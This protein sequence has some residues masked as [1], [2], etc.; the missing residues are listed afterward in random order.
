VSTAFDKAAAEFGAIT[1]EAE[2]ER[3]LARFKLTAMESAPDEAFEPP[4]RTLGQYLEDPIEVPPVLVEPYIV[5]R[6]GITCTIG[7]AGKGK[8]VMNINR[9][10]RWAAGLPMFDTWTDPDKL[11]YLR[12]ANY[13]PL[14]ILVIENEGAGGLFHRQLGIML[15]AEGRFTDEQKALVK[16]NILIWGD[17]GYAGLKLDDPARLQQ[18][19][20][21]CDKYKPDIVFIEPF[22]GLWQGEENS[23]TDMAIVADAL[24]DVAS[25]FQCG[26][27]L[28]HHERKSGTGDDGEKMS[29]GRGSTV[30]EG[31]V[32]VMENFEAV[33]GGEF[34]ELLWSKSRHGGTPNPV[35]MEWDAESWWYN[36]VPEDSILEAIIMALRM[37][38]DEPMS[39]HDL[40]EATEESK[41]RLRK[42]ANEAAKTGRLKKM[43][44]VSDGRGSTGA[45]YRLPTSEHDATGGLAI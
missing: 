2:R 29:A 21:G 26:I 40:H 19:K 31:V 35:R 5:V 10:F 8:T 4:I 13:E 39:V 43:P 17:G 27:M 33:K 38:A 3:W 30:L 44:S 45:R 1:E 41:D 23:A 20:D 25:E 32:S 14:R 11:H 28:S 34:R 24:S 36:H 16:E 42:A 37:N 18:V 6:G 22:R 7:R 12:P 9:M 15:H